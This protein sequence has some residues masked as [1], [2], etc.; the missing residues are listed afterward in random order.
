MPELL[1]ESVRVS[2]DHGREFEATNPLVIHL[3]WIEGFRVGRIEA[4][5]SG[6]SCR[7]GSFTYVA[8]GYE[9]HTVTVTVKEDPGDVPHG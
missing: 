2:R 5:D 4:R 1:D 3:E 8:L 9:K 7:N 6:S